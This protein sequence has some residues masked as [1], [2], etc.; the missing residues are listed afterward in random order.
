MTPKHWADDLSP[1]AHRF[2]DWVARTTPMPQGY[3]PPGQRKHRPAQ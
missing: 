3:L 1:L 2:I